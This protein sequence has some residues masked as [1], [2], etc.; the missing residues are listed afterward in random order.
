MRQKTQQQKLAILKHRGQKVK[1]PSDIWDN[2]KQI[3]VFIFRSICSL[4]G[5]SL[6]LLC[7]NGIGHGTQLSVSLNSFQILY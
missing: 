1:K 4:R 6:P 7:T 3:N 2:V 5:E